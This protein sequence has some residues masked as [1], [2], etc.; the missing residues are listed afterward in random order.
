MGDKEFKNLKHTAKNYLIYKNG[1]ELIKGYKPDVVL[2]NKNNFIIMESEVSTSRKGYIGGMI[3]AAKFL[4]GENSGILVYVIQVRKN[5]TPKQIVTHLR[6]YFNW[7]KTLTRLE[8][9]FVISDKDYYVEKMP[10]EIFSEEF[11]RIAEKV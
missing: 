10:L 8:D 2:K 5:T 11:I 6:D 3:K 9:I 4:T 7:I 1:Q